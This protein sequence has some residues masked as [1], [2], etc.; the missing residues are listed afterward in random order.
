MRSPTL[1]MT[2]RLHRDLYRYLFPGDG[3]EAAAVLLCNQGSGRNSQRL[4]AAELIN[5][6]YEMSQRSPHSVTWPFELYFNTERICEVDQLGQSIVT[7]HSHPN[8]NKKFSALDDCN[9]RELFKS[10]NGWFDDDHINGAAL[11]TSNGELVARS[12]NAKGEFGQFR[13]VGVCGNSIKIWKDSINR[14]QT[15]YSRKLSQTFGTGTLNLLQSLRVGVVGCSGTGS[16]VVELLTRNC[17]GELVLVDD[18]TIEEKNLN[19]I[20]NG[21][22]ENAKQR[23]PKVFAI[24]NSLE[25]LGLSTSVDIYEELTDSPTVVSSLIDCDVIFG[26]VDSAGGRYHLE[27]VASAY[28]IPYFDVGVH[29]EADGMGD[30]S[31]ADA[32]SHYVHP[33]GRS[34]LSR[35]AYTMDQ[36]VAENWKRTDEEYYANQRNAGYLAAVGDEQPAVMSL[37]MQAACLAFNDFLARIHSFRLDENEEFAIQRFRLVHGCFESEKDS[38]RPHP[39]FE[40]FVGTGDRS[41]LVKNN[42]RRD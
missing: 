26:C 15:E 34:L 12:V 7:V 31:A 19:R 39:L 41:I 6:P 10:I 9:D 18:D 33:N 1:N 38:D 35:G 28:L 13:S 2:E 29:I 16:I 36:V 14:H 3:L 11:M 30:I 21:T 40:R 37:N 42:T 22:L 27:C 4:V 8:G 5:L 24:K 32:V 17:V 20:V 23:L 25:R